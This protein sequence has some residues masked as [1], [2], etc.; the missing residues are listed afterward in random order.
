MPDVQEPNEPIAKS[1]SAEVPDGDERVF[2]RT[3]EKQASPKPSPVRSRP[4]S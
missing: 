4:P 1:C 3:V 2:S